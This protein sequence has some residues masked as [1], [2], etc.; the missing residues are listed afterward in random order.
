MPDTSLIIYFNLNLLYRFAIFE[1]V[2]FISLSIS[3]LH[4][5]LLPIILI[6]ECQFSHKSF[7]HQDG[8]SCR[9]DTIN[10]RFLWDIR[11][12]E[13]PPLKKGGMSLFAPMPFPTNL[14]GIR[15]VSP[16]ATI[17]YTYWFNL[18]VHL[19]L[20]L[21]ISAAPIIAIKSS[22]DATSNAIR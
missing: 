14:L 18:A 4:Y 3:Q 6:C 1:K 17:Q 20:C 13:P 12:S 10:P 22:T 8:K 11:P 15:T 16:A 5:I 7:R 21:A 2:V 9:H 19:V